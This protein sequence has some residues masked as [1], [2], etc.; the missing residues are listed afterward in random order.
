MS[1]LLLWLLQ[2]CWLLCLQQSCSCWCL[3]PLRS[4]VE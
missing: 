3:I 2:I 1:R 4:N